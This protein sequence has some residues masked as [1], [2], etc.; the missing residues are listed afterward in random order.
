MWRYF[1]SQLIPLTMGG[2]YLRE[3]RIWMCLPN[4]EILLS[5]YQFFHITYLSVYHFWYKENPILPTLGAF[6][7]ICSKYT[8]S[9]NLGS[10]TH[11]PLYPISRKCTSKGRHIHVYYVNVRTPLTIFECLRYFEM[12]PL[13]GTKMILKQSKNSLMWTV[14][15]MLSAVLFVELYINANYNKQTLIVSKFYSYALSYFVIFKFS[16]EM[17]MMFFWKI[18][19]KTQRNILRIWWRNTACP[20]KNLTIFARNI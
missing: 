9:L 20:S 11:R 16:A 12:I 7:I 6:T 19:L 3:N 4:I 14:S 5:Q 15:V 17:I 10:F 18:R 2:G 13:V 8:Q 1:D